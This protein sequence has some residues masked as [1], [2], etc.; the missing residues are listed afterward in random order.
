MH[1]EPDPAVFLMQIWVLILLNA[2]GYLAQ[3]SSV[4]SVKVFKVQSSSSLQNFPSVESFT[5]PWEFL[6]S[7]TTG[8]L[9]HSWFVAPLVALS[10]AISSLQA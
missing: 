1:E 7:F 10:Q 8:Y 4:A 2:T 3:S 5:Q 6:C 9:A